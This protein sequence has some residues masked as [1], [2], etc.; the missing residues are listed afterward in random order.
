MLLS[1]VVAITLAA[2]VQSPAADR[3]RAED[4][5]RSGRNAEALEL[6]ARVVDANPADVE[7]RLWM[8]RLALRL[9]RTAD[10]ESGFRA[11]LQDHPADVDA[12][13][14]LG[15]VFTRN[16]SWEDALAILTDAE[17]D[18]GQN[19]D[20]FGALAR[21]Y[22]RSGDD[23]RALEYFRRARA[24]S[25]DDPD[26]A[27]GFEGVA[28]TYGHWIAVEGFGQ[29][30]A[31]GA[32]VESGSVTIDLRVIPRLH[33][34]A[35]ARIQNGPDYSDHLAGGGLLWRAT[36]S[37]TV[38]AHV[39]GGSGNTA[40]PRIDASGEVVHY[41]GVFEA[42]AWVRRLSFAGSDLVAVSPVLAWDREP[43][44]LDTRYTYSRSSF[45][46]TSQSRGD[47]SVL[48]RGTWQAW[49]RVAVQGA[50]AYGI[51]SFEDLTADRLG[52]LG[53]TTLAGGLRIDL[54][55]VTRIT[56]TWEHQWRSNDTQI[57][58]F[59]VSV[60]QFIP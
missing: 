60:V 47:H 48:L 18:A 33:L 39:F 22:R 15:M 44:R 41:A 55:S 40:L 10:A 37:T 17:R 3:N 42:G 16:G 6:F 50:Y 23:R 29:T 9:G 12:R 51:E 27:L 49:R 59:T 56:T 45:D 53:T 36:R 7:A 19:A 34:D 11:V 31:P 54:R 1:F 2:A 25:P 52:S 32:D 28:R 8:A 5:A 20:L 57:N 43:W 14:G 30:G 21:A 58:R 24:L 35:S 4:L 46:D 26:L 13:I 38:A